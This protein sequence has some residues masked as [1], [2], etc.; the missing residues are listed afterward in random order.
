MKAQRHL[1]LFSLTI[2]LASAPILS[3]ARGASDGSGG[4]GVVQRDAG[5][6][7]KSVETLDL[8]E[9][10]TIYDR[11]P[12][13]VNNI[14][15]AVDDALVNLSKSF[16]SDGY[17]S[18]PNLPEDR[19]PACELWVLRAA[20]KRFLKPDADF[21]KLR[22]VELTPTDDAFELAKP[23]GQRLEQLVNYQMGAPSRDFAG[24]L[25]LV[26][27]D[28]WDKMD[29]ANQA[30][31]IVHEAFYNALRHNMNESNSV[32]VRR[33]VSF[34][35]SGGKFNY[36]PPMAPAPGQIVCEGP[37]DSDTKMVISADLSQIDFQSINGA[38]LIGITEAARWARKEALALL[39]D[40]S[41]CAGQPDKDRF[42]LGTTHLDGPVEFDR[43]LRLKSACRNGENTL[44]LTDRA[45][46]SRQVRSYPLT[47]VKK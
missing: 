21:K 8:W 27:E 10:R 20:A 19:G 31:L 37:S 44:V 11:D 25:I 36:L 30:A 4:I 35:A 9:G 32:R 26:N 43:E 34:V 28:L 7:I 3:H 13:P 16:P 18:G 23:A 41:A 24:G 6:E 40:E 46:P 29:P 1:G 14:A 39:L 33:A 22:N 38:K 42:N 12:L 17:C 47:C 5:G 45:T 2:F 15:Q